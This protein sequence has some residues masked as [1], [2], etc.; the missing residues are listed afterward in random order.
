MI[1]MTGTIPI[2]YAQR[3]YNIPVTL[4][5]SERYPQQPPIAY[6]TPTQDMI[7]KDNHASVDASGYVHT[8]SFARW[9]Q[10]SE[11][12]EVVNDMVQVF[13]QD[14]PLFAKVRQRPVTQYPPVV[15][16]NETP[17]PPARPTT[18]TQNPYAPGHQPGPQVPSSYPQSDGTAQSYSG[19]KTTVTAAMLE[20]HFRDITIRALQERMQ[21][22]LAVLTPAGRGRQQRSEEVY[23]VLKQRSQQIQNGIQMLQTERETYEYNVRV[24]DAMVRHMDEW[25]SNLRVPEE[26]EGNDVTPESVIVPQDEL[27]AQLL[28]AQAEDLAAEDA[29]NALDELLQKEIINVDAYLKQVLNESLMENNE[30]NDCLDSEAW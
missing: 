3:T 14:P 2:T 22:S 9:H 20:G 25:K 19:G 13:G 23:N 1:K 29:L 30:I 21:H 17:Q 24:M 6:V 11:L 12:L 4:W 27:T 10:E 7:I 8:P 26:S 5:I 18:S 15:L 28:D 16:G